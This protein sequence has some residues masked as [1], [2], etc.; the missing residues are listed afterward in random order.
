MLILVIVVF[1]KGKLEKMQVAKTP[2]IFDG[3]GEN[4]CKD[5]DGKLCSLRRRSKWPAACFL[6]SSS[7]YSDQ[8][9]PKGMKN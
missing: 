3:S 5:D 7:N 8:W 2:G 9:L 6:C 1:S 4:Y